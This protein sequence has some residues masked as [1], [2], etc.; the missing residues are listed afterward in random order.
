MHAARQLFAKHGYEN[1]QTAAI[2]REAGTSESQLIRY[3]GGK[4]GLLH[5][6]FDEAWQPLNERVHDLLIDVPDA[7]RALL[8]ILGAVLTVFDRDRDLATLFLLE[9]RRIRAGSEEVR[10]SPGF[11]A[12]SET[13]R[14]LIARGQK[15]GSFAAALD[16]HAMAVALM[17]AVEAMARERLLARRAARARAI[18]DRQLQRIFAAILDGFSSARQG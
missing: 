11:V 2:A 16:A 17:G 3:F 13:V 14:R 12:F 8:T 10:L 9:G 6:I 7:R 5:A 18:S 1:T 15:E 4:A